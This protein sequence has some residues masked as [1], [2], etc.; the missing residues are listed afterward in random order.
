[1][2]DYIGRLRSELEYWMRQYRKDPYIAKKNILGSIEPGAIFDIGAHC[3]DTTAAYA[4]HFTESMIYSFEPF[5]DSYDKLKTRFRDNQM[6]KVYQQAISN[7]SGM[8]DFYSYAA[9]AGNSLLAGTN[10]AEKWVDWPDAMMLKNVIK[11]RVASI[12]EFCR[13]EG[14]DRIMI[15]KMDVQ[16]GELL[17]LEGAE[18]MLTKR[19]IC[20]IYSELLFVPLYVGQAEYYQVCEFLAKFGYELFDMYNFRYDSSGRIKWCDGLFVGTGI[21]KPK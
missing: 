1:M 18:E 12:D 10:E 3:G 16:G 14:I 17:A 2:A 7:R 8:M 21:Q 20:L 15:L 13:N 6:I 5:S 11:V 4:K 19:A 9:S